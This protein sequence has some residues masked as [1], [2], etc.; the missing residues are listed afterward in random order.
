MNEQAFQAFQAFFKF[1]LYLSKI[2]HNFDDDFQKNYTMILIF[3]PKYLSLMSFWQVFSITFFIGLL[4][5]MSPGSLLT[6][7]IIESLKAKKKAYLVGL[8]ISSGHALIELV[9]IIVLMLGLGLLLSYPVILISI[10]VIGGGILVF[11]SAQILRDIQKG[12]IDVSFL[13]STQD[14]SDMIPSNGRGRLY[15]IHPFFAAILFLMS[16]PHWWLFWSTAGMSIILDNAISFQNIPS[17]IGLVI[18]KELGVYLWY[19]FIATAVGYSSRF[20]TKK[21]YLG[22]LIACAIF[23]LGYGMYLIIS[24]LLSFL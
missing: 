18:G 22:I 1:F 14:S 19:T 23:M 20:L 5:A 16:N 11:F 10:G 7:T 17:F 24:P 15:N 13:E 12:H 4:G 8:F 2:H 9:L 21:I 6:Y 3:D